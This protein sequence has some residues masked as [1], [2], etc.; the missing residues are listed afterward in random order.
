MCDNK[1][2][3]TDIKNRTCYHFDNIININDLDIDNILMN[4]K[5]CKNF[6]VYKNAYNTLCGSK[7]LH[8]NFNKVNEYVGIFDTTRYPALFYSEK[9]QW[10][11]Q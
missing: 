11:I 8:I 10:N 5:T 6:M 2:K 3:E 1:L 7:P 9:F 4:E